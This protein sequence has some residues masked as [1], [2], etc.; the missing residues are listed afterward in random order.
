MSPRRHNIDFS[1]STQTGVRLQD[2]A[3]R[4][5]FARRG[6]QVHTHSPFRVIADSTSGGGLTLSR[7]WH[8][9]A[10]IQRDPVDGVGL[11]VLVQIDGT[12]TLRVADSEKTM[13]L[14]PGSAVLVPDGASYALTAEA[15]VARIE[16]GLRHS[17]G[18]VS[19][20]QPVGWDDNPYTRVLIAAV[21]AALSPPVVDPAT[22]GY[23]HLKAAIRVLLFASSAGAPV[24]ASANLQGSAAV[25]YQRAQAVIERDAIKP[26]FRVADLAA[27]LRVS[28]V[29]LRRVFSR[30]GTTPLKAIRDARVRNARLHLH[31][32]PTP[33]RAEL[34]RIAQIAGFSSVRHM[35]ES[36]AATPDPLLHAEEAMD[37]AAL[38]VSDNAPSSVIS[39]ETTETETG[40]VHE[41]LQYQLSATSGRNP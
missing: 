5:W 35:R 26:E 17:I 24:S 9:R 30:A 19:D 39:P 37:K 40:M 41:P 20:N 18:L 28:E 11:T 22:A 4:E 21:N 6:Q 8:D 27:E 23:A 3:G 36:L 33:T 12:A 31:S 15:P 34:Q 38:D 13:T 25:L 1:A 29:Y 14:V 10:S 32:R 7:I 16:V 2:G